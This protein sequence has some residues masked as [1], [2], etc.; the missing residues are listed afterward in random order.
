MDSILEWLH[1][2]KPRSQDSNG[3]MCEKNL[4]NSLKFCIKIIHYYDDDDTIRLSR[5]AYIVSINML[6]RKKYEYFFLMCVKL[7]GCMT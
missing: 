2:I 5:S 3:V 4:E 6:R 7:A 1:I